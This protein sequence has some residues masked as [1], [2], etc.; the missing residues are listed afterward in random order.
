MPTPAASTAPRAVPAPAGE[1]FGANVNYLFNDHLYTPSGIA[2]QLAALRATGATIART[3]ALW[4]AAEP[5]PPRGGVHRY[6]WS[7]DDQIA[8]SLAA[9]GLQWL[10]IIDYTAP[11]DQSIA[12][13]DH[14]PPR[15]PADF[16]AFAGAFAARYGPGGVFWRTH[17]RLPSDPV[18]TFEIWNEPDNAEFWTPTPDASAYAELYL[19][20]RGA[21]TAADP[22]ARVIVGGLTNPGV[23]LPAML[24]AMPALR[25]HVDG[26][27]IH[28]YGATPAVVLARVRGARGTLDALGMAAVPLYVTEVGWT[29]RPPHALSWAPATIRPRYIEQTLAALGHSGCAIAATALYTWVSPQLDV[30]DHEDWFGIHPPGGAGSSLA[31]AAFTAGIHDAL[32][33]GPTSGVCTG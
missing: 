6:D 15:I 21:I 30:S 31:T 22:Q 4:E 13:R 5:A 12:G 16:A 27:A 7:F 32:T 3:D 20:A 9:A 33:P 11:W 18:A 2:T 28:P 23:F 19:A 17:P 8:A 25:D 1:E 14:S 26:V 10:P 29:T 24:A